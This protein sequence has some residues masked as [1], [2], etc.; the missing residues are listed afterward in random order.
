METAPAR[1]GLLDPFGSVSRDQLGNYRSRRV[2]K[3][4]RNGES[5]RLS[6]RRSLSEEWEDSEGDVPKTSK[7]GEAKGNTSSFLGYLF[8]K[9][10]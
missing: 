2:K 7:E 9:G 5:I 4:P 1:K 6:R 10:G 8:G 3:R